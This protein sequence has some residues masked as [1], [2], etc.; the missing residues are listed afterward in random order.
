MDKLSYDVIVIGAGSTGENVADRAVKGGLTAAI[1][2]SD[3][4]GGECSYWACMPSKALLRPGSALE[5][6]RSVMGAR[7][8][9]TGK[10]DVPA[11][12]KRRDS[13]VSNWNDSGQAKWLR[14]ANIDLL[15]G[16]GRLTD[17]RQV[18][19]TDKDGI[20]TNLTARQA[21]AVCTGSRPAIPDI[22]GLAETRPWTSREATSVSKVP[23][24]LAIL[25]GGVV[26][27]EMATA[28]KQLGTEEVTLIERGARLIPKCESF[29]SELLKTA[30]EQRGI[31]VL[32]NTTVQRVDRQQ[33]GVVRIVLSNGQTLFADELL[34]ATSR[35]PRTG[36]LGL[37]TIGLKP[38][39]WLEVDDSMRVKEVTGGW[40]YAA[41]DV[42][43][44][45]LLTHMGKYQARVCGDVIAARA[46]GNTDASM[47]EPW[48]RYSATADNC[49]VPQVIFTD[50]EVATVGLTEAEAK[51]RGINVRAVDYEIGSVAGASLYADNYKGHARMVVDQTRGVAVGMTLIGPSVGELIH[52][53]AIAIVGAVP[54]SRLWH[55]VPSYP[56]ISEVWLRLLE[57]LGL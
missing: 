24:R 23:R 50:P 26:A 39:S 48:T 29:A 8:A 38:G 2:E 16:H 19:V 21:V 27:C 33:D 56:T 32:A 49:A 40:L 11:V 5:D 14:H 51:A 31:A 47:P 43:H 3:L 54:L 57:T 34:V 13:T 18:S 9:V 7:E 15:R 4:V 10:L 20:T 35:Q 45:A 41:G 52:A 55:A 44:R 6:A 12:F 1:V 22:P 36:E 53:A 37:E 42:N 46:K 30:F 28:W 17:E 25:G